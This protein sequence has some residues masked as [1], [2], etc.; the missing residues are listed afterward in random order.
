M[1]RPTLTV[2]PLD[3]PTCDDFQTV[4][5]M[6]G[7]AYDCRCMH[8][9]Q[10]NDEWMGNDGVLSPGVV[11]YLNRKPVAWC[12]FGDRCEPPQGRRAGLDTAMTGTIG[13]TGTTGI[14]GCFTA[15]RFTEV[16]RPESNRPVM[17]FEAP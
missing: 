4:L 15:A 9:R 12:G 14:A 16:A 3:S 6:R 17:R 8:W 10:S 13:P 5:D 1:N 2:K 7:G 11:A